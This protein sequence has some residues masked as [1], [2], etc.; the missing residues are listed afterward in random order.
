MSKVF[1]VDARTQ[2]DR[3][4]VPVNIQIFDCFCRLLVNDYGLDTDWV[5]N[6]L[7][8]YIRRLIVLNRHRLD[9]SAVINIRLAT[10]LK[11]PFVDY[12]EGDALFIDDFKIPAVYVDD[13]GTRW[14]GMWADDNDLG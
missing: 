5:P 6:L 13:N 4:S 10:D 1:V 14:I 7:K 11:G 12:L 8:S 3:I 9:L 2:G